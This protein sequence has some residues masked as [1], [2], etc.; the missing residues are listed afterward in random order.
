MKKRYFLLIMIFTLLLTACSSSKLSSINYNELKEKLDNKESFVLYLSSKD[1]TLE[2]TLNK[3]LEEY[4]F[5]A[6]KINT[7]KLNDE[8]KLSLKLKFD[9]ADPSIIFIIDGKDPTKLSHVSDSSI[10]K[11]SLIARLK[12][13]NFIKEE[14]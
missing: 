5:T 13:M 6:Y 8:D 11:N 2:E 12:D 9:Y 10:R 1:D 4:N 7:D 3:V 14:K